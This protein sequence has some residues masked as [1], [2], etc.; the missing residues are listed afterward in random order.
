MIVLFQSC[1]PVV[2]ERACKLLFDAQ[3]TTLS[4]TIAPPP[5]PPR[6]QTGTM[7]GLPLPSTTICTPLMPLLG[8]TTNAHVVLSAG[9]IHSE[10]G[11]C[12]SPP[13]CNATEVISPPTFPAAPCPL[14]LSRLMRRRVASLPLK[15]AR[16]AYLLVPLGRMSTL[17]LPRSRSLFCSVW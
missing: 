8:L 11:F 16:C 6:L 2:G 7:V 15:N 5:P 9:L 13:V 1:A 4:A 3:Y 17:V 10:I 14:M 12:T